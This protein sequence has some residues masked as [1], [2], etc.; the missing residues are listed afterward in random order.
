MRITLFRIAVAEMDEDELFHDSPVELQEAL[1]EY[2]NERGLIKEFIVDYVSYRDEDI[3]EPEDSC[4]EEA[5]K[6][7]KEKACGSNI[8]MMEDYKEGAY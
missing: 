6:A 2:C 1:R 7:W 4:D 3:E 5:I 8:A